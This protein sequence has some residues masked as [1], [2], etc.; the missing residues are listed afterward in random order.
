L[1]CLLFNKIRGKG[2]QVLPRSEG[3]GRGRGR[4]WRQGKK[5]PNNICTYEYINKEKKLSNA[6]I[7]CVAKDQW[8]P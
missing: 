6:F 2:K 4:W 3:A 8:P 7:T 5:C 1:L